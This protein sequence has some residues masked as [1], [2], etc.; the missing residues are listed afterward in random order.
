MMLELHWKWRY[1]TTFT[2]CSGKVVRTL[3]PKSE[4]QPNYNFQAIVSQCCGNVKKL[5]NFQH[6]HNVGITLN[7]CCVSMFT[8]FCTRVEEL[9]HF[10]SCQNVLLKH[11]SDTHVALPLSQHQSPVLGS[12]TARTFTQHYLNHISMLVVNFGEQHCHNI[13]CVLPECCLNIGLQC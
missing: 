5:C 4:I 7:E 2:Q 11:H 10:Q 12:D 1:F 8:Q 13:A 3:V 9:C 6:C